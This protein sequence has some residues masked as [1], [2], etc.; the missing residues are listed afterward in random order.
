METIGVTIRA[1]RK[2]KGLTQAALA[3][4]VGMSRATISAIE[5]GTVTEIGIRKVEAVLQVLG[6]TLVAVPA[7][8]MPTLDELKAMKVHG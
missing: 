8:R 2:A 5:N 7:R 3:G 1:N 4:K 6:Y